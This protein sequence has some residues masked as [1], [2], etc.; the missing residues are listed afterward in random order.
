MSNNKKRIIRDLKALKAQVLQLLGEL[1]REKDE[2]DSKERIGKKLEA[3]SEQSLQLASDLGREKDEIIRQLKETIVKKKQIVRFKQYWEELNKF[4]SNGYKV[5][6]GRTFEEMARQ[7]FQIVEHAEGLWNNATLLFKRK[8]YATACFLSIVCIEECAKINFGMFQI[9]FSLANSTPLTVNPRRSTLSSHIRKHF[10]AACSGA[11]VNSRMDRVFGIAKVNSFISDCEKGKLE[12]L[13]QSCLYA[14]IDR[15]RH[16][17]LIPMKE[18]S[19]EQALF[20]VCL[21][22]ELL[23]EAGG[24][25]PSTWQRLLNKVDKFEKENGIR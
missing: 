19:R 6:T 11:L 12:K 2:S 15:R 9:Y 24:I 13:R 20:Y 21:A 7:L 3:I 25:E 17:V 22:G 16:G 4:L 18:I 14:D 5:V 8:G 23:A 10:I 1:G